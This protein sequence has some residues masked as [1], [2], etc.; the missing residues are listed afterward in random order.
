[1][2]PLDPDKETRILDSALNCYNRLGFESITIKAIS[3]DSG[4][5]VG[6]IYTYFESKSDILKALFDKIRGVMVLEFPIDFDRRL[7]FSEQFAIIWNNTYD[8]EDKY[9]DYFCFATDYVKHNG[10]S[11]SENRKE[12]KDVED[13]LNLFFETGV[14]EKQ[15][16]ELNPLQIVMFMVQSIRWNRQLIAANNPDIPPLS[17]RQLMLL[18]WNGIQ[19]V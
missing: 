3:E 19:S 2:R 11:D 14:A 10:L 9:F 18:V 17:R 6:A 13:Y 16:K 7:S 8:F 1:M 12:F 4:L 15:F 5:S